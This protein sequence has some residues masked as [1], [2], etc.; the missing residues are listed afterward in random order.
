MRDKRCMNSLWVI[1]EIL[2]SLK[3]KKIRLNINEHIKSKEAG[4]IQ[5]K[6]LR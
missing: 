6:N 3:K 5:R 1:G 2:L 4:Q